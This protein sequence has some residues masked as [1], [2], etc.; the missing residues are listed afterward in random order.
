MN[1]E[2][3][4]SEHGRARHQMK[5]CQPARSW[6]RLSSRIEEILQ[7]SERPTIGTDD[8]RHRDV[9]H[10][11]AFRPALRNT[12]TDTVPTGLNFAE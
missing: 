4:F 6:Q 12:R 3:L 11:I 5:G 1:H 8:K 9:F 2:S 10:N 7:M